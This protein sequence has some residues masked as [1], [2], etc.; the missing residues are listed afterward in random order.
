MF[1]ITSRMFWKKVIDF[2][3]K[4][5]WILKFDNACSAVLK[6]IKRVNNI[7]K[8]YFLIFHFLLKMR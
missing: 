4:R 7:K 5:K 8:L 6:R 3:S 1:C 2:E